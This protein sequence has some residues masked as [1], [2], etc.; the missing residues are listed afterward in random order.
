MSLKIEQDYQRFRQ[1]VRGKVR[2]NLRRFMST[3]EM[4]G[5]QGKKYISIPLPQIDIPHFKY[6]GKQQGGVA[7]GS[8]EP[9][10]PVSPSD[11]G[12]EAGE[13]GD[14]EGKHV[15]EV[16]LTYEELADLLRE[17]LELPKIEPKGQAEISAEKAVYR[18]IRTTGPE[19]LRH[20][21]RTY[22]QALKRQLL[23]GS[24]NPEDPR[25][26]PYREDRRYRSFREVKLPQSRAAIIYMMDVSGSMGGEQKEIV[27]RLSFWI[28]TWL[29]SQY[30][31]IDSRYI[32]HDA[33]AR[34]VDRETFF[35][36]R[37][38]GGTIIS[39][40][41]K[42]CLELIDKHYDPSEW[43]IYPFHFSDGDNWSDTDTQTCITLLKDELFPRVNQFSYGQVD[44]DYGSG[45][46]LNDLLA[47]FGETEN[48]LPI[49]TSRIQNRDRILDSIKDFFKK[50]R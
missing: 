42:T 43:N 47:H 41:Y 16:D 7:T 10:T 44:S 17:E 2:E 45:K 11:E 48:A 24:Y 19:S 33:T 49:V 12:D 46:F 35:H 40:A 23:S 31:G 26:V 9:G 6:N 1:I 13:A 32:I 36:T 38:S 50:G 3:G 5:K 15:L 39:S 4:I 30:K 28:D 34:E 27:R 21:K 29:R 18:G 20:T 37:E 14:G 25:I 22:K 8:G